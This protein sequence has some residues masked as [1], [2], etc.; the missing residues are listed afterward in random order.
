MSMCMVLT[1]QGLQVVACESYHHSKWLASES[2]L[3]LQRV[4]ACTWTQLYMLCLFGQ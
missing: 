2:D 4:S 1:G 3:L